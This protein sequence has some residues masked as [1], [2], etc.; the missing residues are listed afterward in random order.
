VYESHVARFRLKTNVTQLT[1]VLEKL[2]KIRGVSYEWNEL[3]KSLGSS[4]ERREIGM[5][6][7]EVEAVFPELVTSLTRR[8]IDVSYKAIDYSRMTGVLI[9]ALKELKGEK[10]AQQKQIV[11]LEARLV[12]LEQGVRVSSSPVQMSSF[13]LSAGWLLFGGLFLLGLALGQRW[14]TGGRQ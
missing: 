13:V 3:Y 10:E 6:A 7:Q 9:E 2:E 4:A 1:G 14:R 8:G 11:A 5:I 12:A